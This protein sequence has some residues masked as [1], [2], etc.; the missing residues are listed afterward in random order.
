[1]R[2]CSENSYGKAE[3]GSFHVA[4][5]FFTS[6]TMGFKKG[7]KGKGKVQKTPTEDTRPS[8]DN[9]LSEILENK[10]FTE[11]YTRQKI[12]SP[13]EFNIFMET[14]KIPL[15]V[16][17]RI[18]GSRKTALE[19]RE[20][21]KS[22]LFPKLMNIEIEGVK[23]PPPKPLEWYPNELGW[24]YECG[25]SAL[26]SSL[27]VK[28]FH[29]FLV[30]ENDVGNIS[31][32][33]AVSMIPVLLMD[34]KPGQ[35]VLDM[36]AAP[37]SKTAQLLEGIVGDGDKF[38][39][40]L[41]IANDFDQKRAYML[42]HQ[43][44]RLQTPCLLVTNHEAQD[45]PRIIIEKENEPVKALQFDRILCDVPCSG[46]GT[47][48]KNKQVWK[49]WNGGNGNGL[50][51]VQFSILN[52]GCEMLK[53]GGRLVYSTCSFNPVENEAVVA[54]IIAQ[55]DGALKLVDMSKS[56]P[57][58][59]RNPGISTW[60][61]R[62]KDGDYHDSFPGSEK[63]LL[64]TMF[65]P[66]NAEELGLKKC[67]RVYPYMNNCGG[68]FVA[69]FEKIKSYGS[70]D[71]FNNIRIE[72]AK[73]A[74]LEKHN[75]SS[76][77]EKEVKKPKT[78]VKNEAVKET[79]VVAGKEVH[80]PRSTRKER[81]ARALAEKNGTDEIVANSDGRGWQGGKE[82]PFIFVSEENPIIKQCCETY[83]LK[84]SFPRENFLVRTAED[85]QDFS[86]IYVVSQ[87]VKEVLT[88]RHS[89]SLKVV[90]TGVKTFVKNGGK[91][92]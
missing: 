49:T 68:F 30:S 48:R 46:D 10:I 21:M 89:G 32:Q 7:R 90:N 59:K 35:Y 11:Y 86:C 74:K 26:R 76:D 65:P 23:I 36:C 60:V 79:G 28:E 43:A 52:R 33:E 42:V 38:P 22:E 44:K 72:R 53:V 71:K 87:K 85:Q 31:R 70:I 91:A 13:V 20:F 5:F 54:N 18:T 58:L 29:R 24:V 73:T 8:R 37:G 34:I 82:S 78:E 3:Q 92:L 45:F 19:L 75:L 69:V 56:L 6:T 84:A 27:N 41:V 25:R 12:L 2:L 63:G 14:N 16:S 62:D 17:F 77:D 66:T 88:S 50:H 55:S 61:V 83:G 39:D 9:F 15:P 1:M 4:D 64:P 47:I 81:Q 57:T 40:G 67:L 51:K 80:Q